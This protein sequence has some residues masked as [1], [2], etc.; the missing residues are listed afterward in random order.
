MDKPIYQRLLNAARSFRQN[1]Q[2]GLNGDALVRRFM[3]LIE[4]QP[5]SGSSQFPA[6]GTFQVAGAQDAAVSFLQYVMQRLCM[7]EL[8]DF[9]G[10]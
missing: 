6:Q 8:T 9:L 1:N 2:G 5:P 7:S 4:T 3:N 10:P